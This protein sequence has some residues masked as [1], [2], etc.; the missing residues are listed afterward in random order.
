MKLLPNAEMAQVAP[1]TKTLN[2][3]AK[4]IMPEQSRLN[5][6]KSRENLQVLSNKFPYG[7]WLIASG[8]RRLRG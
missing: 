1:A 4:Q 3:R 6:E 7:L 5:P 8:A 2:S